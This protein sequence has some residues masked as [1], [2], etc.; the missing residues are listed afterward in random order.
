MEEI[1]KMA[2][3]IIKDNNIE[4]VSQFK[5][6]MASKIANRKQEILENSKELK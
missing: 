6:I 1:K 4:A 5:E 2:N 3:N